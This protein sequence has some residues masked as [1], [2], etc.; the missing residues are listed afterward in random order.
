VPQTISAVIFDNLDP[1]KT[2]IPMV[3]RAEDQSIFG[4][5][6]PPLSPVLPSVGPKIDPVLIMDRST[7]HGLQVQSPKH[8]AHRELIDAIMDEYSRRRTSGQWDE[9]AT[10]QFPGLF[11]K[12]RVGHKNLVVSITYDT[13]EGVLTR[14][15]RQKG[16]ITRLRNSA[17]FN[18]ETMLNLKKT[19]SMCTISFYRENAKIRPSF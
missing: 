9:W 18:E 7:E 19:S 3:A 10:L 6:P 17:G 16:R 5:P 2:Y 14:H 12:L 11:D 8:V 1:D 4:L 15:D 13:V